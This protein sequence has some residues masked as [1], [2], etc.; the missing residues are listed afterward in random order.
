MRFDLVLENWALFAEGVWMTVHLTALAL[1]IGFAIA[2]PAALLRAR[3]APVA[4]PLI[5]AYVYLFR[6][7]PLLVQVYLVYYGL[8]QFDVVRDGPL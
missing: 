6:G 8:A 2:L 5:N 3:R 4:A 7:T 1:V